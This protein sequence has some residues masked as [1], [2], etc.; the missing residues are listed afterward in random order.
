MVISLID[1]ARGGFRPNGNGGDKA[2][3]GKQRLMFQMNYIEN[4]LIICLFCFVL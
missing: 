1:R 2:I 3:E 4:E